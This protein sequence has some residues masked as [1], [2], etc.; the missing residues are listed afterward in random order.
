MMTLTKRM[1]YALIALTHLAR[2]PERVTSAREIAEAHHVPLP[3]LTNILKGLTH[4]GILMSVRG[5][6]GGYCLTR[7]ASAINL[8]ELI[9]VVDGPF[10]FVQCVATGPNTGGNGCT[11]EPTC[12]IRAPAHKIYH[13]LKEFLESVTLAELA[14]VDMKPIELRLWGD[15]SIAT[16]PRAARELAL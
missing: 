5:V 13:R 2:Q 9:R 12:P 15:G 10:Q 4:S 7:G 14:G 11:L 3:I 1:D 8:H 6:Y 16:Q